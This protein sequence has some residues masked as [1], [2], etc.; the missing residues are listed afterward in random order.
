MALDVQT[1]ASIIFV[2]FLTLFILLKRKNM[3]TQKILFPLLY[4]SMYRT[5]YGI[6]FMDSFARRFKKP[7]VFLGYA[8]I[9]VGFPALGFVFVLAGF[10][11]PGF[12]DAFKTELGSIKFPPVLMF[13]KELSNTQLKLS[14]WA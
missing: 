11:S 3:Q 5:Q 13:W 12:T 10:P 1:I 2:L 7:L 14:S 6:K 4:F 8:G 9:A